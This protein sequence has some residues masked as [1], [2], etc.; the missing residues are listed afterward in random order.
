[1]VSSLSF[2]TST[3]VVEIHSR[4]EEMIKPS[5]VSVSET[6][7]KIKSRN[8]TGIIEAIILEEA[9]RNS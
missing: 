1:M 9:D 2:H 6:A 3:T 4:E 5:H 8:F 7:I